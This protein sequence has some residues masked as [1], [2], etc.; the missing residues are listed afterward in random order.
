VA[1]ELAAAEARAA[2]AL[3]SLEGHRQEVLAEVPP[4]FRDV[5]D[6]IIAHHERHYAAEKE[7]LAEAKKVF[8]ARKGKKGAQ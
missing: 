1:K 3:E 4:G 6:L 5:A 7:W 2:A 8:A